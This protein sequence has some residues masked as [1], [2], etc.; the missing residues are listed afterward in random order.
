M[1]REELERK[2]CAA[3]SMVKLMT[4]VANNA[5]VS[6]MLDAHDQVKR[7]PRYKQRV[8]MLYKR[9]IEAW[10]SYENG[11]LYADYNRFFRVD[12]MSDRV[13]KKYGEIS[14]KDYF[15][16]WK[17]LG[18]KAYA[19]ARPFITSLQNKY[20]LSLISHKVENEQPLAWAM[21]GGA[22]LTLAVDICNEAIR[23]SSNE[24][25]IPHVIAHNVFGQFSMKRVLDAWN[26]ALDATED[27][28][29]DLD[30]VEFRNIQVGV[31]QI[32]DLWT[33]PRMFYGSAMSAIPDFDD[34]FRTQGEMKK[35]MREIAE[36]ENETLY[37]LSH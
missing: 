32:A 31:R 30:E 28:S 22:C 14:D 36:I 19:D 23:W 34:L 25:G 3:S 17:G 7:H 1:T 26:V 9:A 27:A 8:K 12:D 18:A 16:F 10:H 35:A 5:A 20:R 37:N 4:G 11:L 29:F 24:Y 21:T 15:D 2:V 13:R 6:V 33:D